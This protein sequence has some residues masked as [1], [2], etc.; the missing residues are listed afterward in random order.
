[1]KKLLLYIS[2]GLGCRN[3]VY[4]T[5][6]DH[7]K[8]NGFEVVI[9]EKVDF[10]FDA[11]GCTVIKYPGVQIPTFVDIL[12]NAKIESELNLYAK[13]FDNDIY[14]IY[15]K[16]RKPKR[17]AAQIKFYLKKVLELKKTLPDSVN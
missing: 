16:S 10:E 8:E 7:A 9:L 15:N 13:Q 5:F 4:S 14:H 6:I 3:Y 11:K 2:D 12:K 17:F 1:M